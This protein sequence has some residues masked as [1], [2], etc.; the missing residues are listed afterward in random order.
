MLY[1]IAPPLLFF[2]SIGGIILLVS[3]V[4]SRIKRRQFSEAIQAEGRRPTKSA[5]ELLNPNEN[6][7]KLMRSRLA[8]TASSLGKSLT[9][10]KELP[11]KVRERRAER[12]KRNQEGP[13]PRSSAGAER[14]G[15][16]PPRS[17]WRQ[18]LSAA[19]EKLSR[20]RGLG[21]RPAP[22]QPE[23]A[24]R[25]SL[26]RIETSSKDALTPRVETTAERLQAFVRKQRAT[27]SPVQEAQA[28][29]GAGKYE[30]AEDILIPY[31]A[32]HPKNAS[33]Y[34][35]LGEVA[36]KRNS[37]D[38]AIEIFEQVIRLDKATPRAYA[39]LGEACLGG[40]RVTRA[41]EALQRAHDA[42]SQDIVV[43]KQLLN[44]G[45]H[46][47]NRVL[48]KSVLQKLIV[49]APDDPSVHLAAEALEAREREREETPTT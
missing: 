27:T 4:V 28:A 13:A 16:R 23:G 3:R 25:I 15:V 2:G 14:S 20:L 47:D 17:S 12:V 38:E 29:L 46:M 8:A 40:G 48:Q 44:I 26:R 19:S 35:V 39:K 21:R 33:A 22:P 9:S 10:L 6:K 43:L 7:I 42:D 45:Q 11:A 31:L 18:Q 37:W 24:P 5:Q 1:D 34:M 32:K 49:L 30:R 36:L 41:L